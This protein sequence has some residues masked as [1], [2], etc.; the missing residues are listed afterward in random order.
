MKMREKSNFQSLDTYIYLCVIVG[1]IEYR[2]Q[3]KLYECIILISDD[4]R[5]VDLEAKG[6]I[7]LMSSQYQN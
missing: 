4:S 1:I 5:R 3:K 2:H 7:N 6:D